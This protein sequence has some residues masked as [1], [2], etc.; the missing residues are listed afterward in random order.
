[1]AQTQAINL[2]Q[3]ALRSDRD[4]E[5]YKPQIINKIKASDD[6]FIKATV[7]TVKKYLKDKKKEGFS[8]LTALMLLKECM[9]TKNGALVEYV[10]KKILRRLG[11]IAQGKDKCLPKDTSDA[12]VKLFSQLLRECIVKWN[13]WFGY[14]KKKNPTKY[15]KTY[16]AVFAKVEIPKKTGSFS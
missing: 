2:V 15:K 10:H 13:E 1:M 16:D 7:D 3:A 11:L 14:D 9:D 12:L 8:K 4:F 5:T 6:V